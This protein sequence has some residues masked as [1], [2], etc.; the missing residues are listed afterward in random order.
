M[1]GSMDFDNAQI[2][3][4]DKAASR[5]E[6]PERDR[7]VLHGALY[8]GFTATELS[9][10]QVQTVLDRDGNWQRKFKLPASYAFNGESRSA[11]LLDADFM[12]VLDDWLAVRLASEWGVGKQ[13]DR[14]RGLDGKSPLFL[15]NRGEPFAMTPRASGS[16][17]LVPSGMNRLL[18]E[19]LDAAGLSDYSPLAFR[20]TWIVRLW[21]QGLSRQDLMK[22][23]GIRRSETIN[24][25][26]RDRIPA[27]EDVFSAFSRQWQQDHA[28]RR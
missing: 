10:L 22:L 5:S 4:L 25:K 27:V 24:R 18:R 1:T 19:L 17:E 20:D 2:A 14:H 3:R 28:A 13:A 15:N 12:Q 9:Q 26:I 23:S 16:D 11:W 8:W 6:Y 21:D 7:A